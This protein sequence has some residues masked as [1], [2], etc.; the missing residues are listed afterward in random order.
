MGGTDASQNEGSNT[1]VGSTK[2]PVSQDFKQEG[3]L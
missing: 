3:T 1:V 2:Q